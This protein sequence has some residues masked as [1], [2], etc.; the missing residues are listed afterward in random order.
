M[1]SY[2]DK[3]IRELVE[4]LTDS[5]CFTNRPGKVNAERL[6]YFIG[7]AQYT[8]WELRRVLELPDR[9]DCQPL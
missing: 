2:T 8:L 1:S 5:L 4:D 3:R 7:Q 6:A 9:E